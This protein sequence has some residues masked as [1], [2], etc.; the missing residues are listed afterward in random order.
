MV[1][2]VEAAEL[3]NMVNRLEWLNPAE[4]SGGMGEAER[5]YS[6]AEAVELA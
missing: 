3:G 1:L 5:I 2:F 4:W 6:M